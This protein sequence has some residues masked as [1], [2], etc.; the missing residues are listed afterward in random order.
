M[1][2]Q[3]AVEDPTGA[4]F[5]VIITQLHGMVPQLELKEWTALAVEVVAVTHAIRLLMERQLQMEALR[6]LLVDAVDLA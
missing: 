6:E 3:V 4:I 5:Q 2:Q 1:F